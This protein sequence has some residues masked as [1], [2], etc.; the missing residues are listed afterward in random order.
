MLVQMMNSLVSLY[1]NLSEQ[2]LILP[3]SLI[4][5]NKI[6][7]RIDLFDDG[8]FI[9]LKNLEES[10]GKSNKKKSIK[11]PNIKLGKSSY[12]FLYGNNDYIFGANKSAKK[13]F[14]TRDFT[15]NLLKDIDIPAVNAL[16][17]F[18]MN[19]SEKIGSIQIR[20][21]KNLS[22]LI[23]QLLLDNYPDFKKINQGKDLDKI[24]YSFSYKGK[25]LIEYKEIFEVWNDYFM[26][27]SN[28]NDLL[29]NQLCLL[30]GNFVKAPRTY[31]KV[32]GSNLFSL[33]TSD[34]DSYL[35]YYDYKDNI[36]A[37][38]APIDYRLC[39]KIE[40]A[41][42]YIENQQKNSFRLPDSSISILTWSNK[43]ESVGEE[44]NYLNFESS[45]TI[46][47]IYKKFRKGKFVDIEGINFDF[48]DDIWVVEIE[49][50]TNG[51]KAIKNIWHNTL[52]IYISNMYNQ[53]KKFRFSY[54]FNGNIEFYTPRYLKDIYSVIYQEGLKKKNYSLVSQL[55]YSLL[56]DKD[57]PE[58]FLFQV[59]QKYFLLVKT[60]DRLTDLTDWIFLKS[61]S[62][63]KAYLIKNY[64]VDIEEDLSMINQS[65]AYIFGK[66][67]RLCLQAQ[68]LVNNEEPN[69]S[70]R[71]RFF[72]QVFSEPELVFIELSK[73]FQVSLKSLINSDIPLKKGCARKYEQLSMSYLSKIGSNFFEKSF[74][75]K[76]S[77]EFIL[78]FN[79]VND[80]F[81]KS[82]DSTV[83]ENT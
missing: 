7:Y 23:Y 37:W 60:T 27:D 47:E 6:D 35:A 8:S 68:I 82:E 13:F 33:N 55:F 56:N 19:L 78:G 42:S 83:K 39:S 52:G 48:S 31:L 15:L 12:S 26:D 59:I 21:E 54:R 50:P 25:L 72:N 64:R 4:L 79:N 2:D 20:E 9:F 58:D 32:G 76:D 18:Y 69:S 5:S 41:F 62:I 77:C 81:E 74:S 71:S 45:L 38:Y 40:S 11:I 53:L 65:N 57:F 73:S 46:E 28:R 36:G 22:E 17:N 43:S 51:R 67:F 24:K 70:L 66:Y 10:S 75:I 29:D 14:E 44:I 80:I 16:K 30:S 3:T 61:L 63:I 34:S 1:D 49:I